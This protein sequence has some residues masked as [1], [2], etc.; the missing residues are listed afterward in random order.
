M[1]PPRS[2][3]HVVCKRR[4]IEKEQELAELVRLGKE[5]R[6]KRSNMK[7]VA[8]ETDRGLIKYKHLPKFLQKR[9]IKRRQERKEKERKKEEERKRE[10]ARQ[11]E[12]KKRD[13]N[14]RKEQQDAKE[15]ERKRAERMAKDER[16]E[17]KKRREEKERRAER[18]TKIQMK[19]GPQMRKP[20]NPNPKDLRTLLD[21][22]E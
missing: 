7:T 4:N 1:A 17:E 9:M 2:I 10:K 18:N 6:E 14:K 20:R 22:Q 21:Q 11:E 19:Y 15:E 3:G 13:E 8:T 16:R 5:V 12:K